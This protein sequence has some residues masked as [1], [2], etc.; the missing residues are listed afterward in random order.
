MLLWLIVS[1]FA[2]SL[3]F[4]IWLPRA[5]SLRRL[6]AVQIV[7]DLLVV[8]GLVFVSGGVASVFTFLYGVVILMAALLIGPSASQKVAVVAVL[9]YTVMGVSMATGWLP[10]PP[11]QAADRY[12]LDLEDIGFSLVSNIVGLSLV[13]ALA[14]NLSQ[15][16]RAAGG[17]LR[18]ATESATRL[19]RLNDDIVRSISSGLFT[20]DADGL[21]V[22]AN[23]AA[24][25]IYRT[26]A[27]ALVGR[28]VDGLLPLDGDA[29]RG[30]GEGSRP[31]GSVFMVGW[32]SAPL[33]DEAGE[34]TGTLYS[35]QDLTEIVEL[36][37]AARKAERLATLGGLSAGLAHEIRNPLSSISGSVEL[38]REAEGLSEVDRRLLSTVIS[39]VD[40]LE[41]LVT[42]MLSVGRPRPLDR[43]NHDLSEIAA[44]VATMAEQGPAP[45]RDVAIALETPDEPVH[46]FVDGAQVRQVILEPPQERAQRHTAGRHG[47]PRCGEPSGR[48]RRDSGAGP[49]RRDRRRGSRT[50]LRIVL[51]RPPPRRGPRPRAGETD[52]R[53]TRSGDPGRQ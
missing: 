9:G 27:D 6:A 23:P 24:A 3:G 7:T 40:R 37:N 50:S 21:V 43:A 1:T 19:Q 14:G 36:R 41:D 4:A 13:A 45:A 53:C 39:E 52:H 49:R 25:I 29:R 18:R 44:Q 30:E 22:S 33:V 17:E 26:S 51:F 31:D 42:T 48:A 12:L 8:T 28:K 38:V 34:S 47:H 35:F 11:D 5:A 2:A 16:L 20:V 32:N 46:A 10:H 15:R